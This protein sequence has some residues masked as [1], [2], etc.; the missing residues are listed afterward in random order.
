VESG[1]ERDCVGDV[2]SWLFDAA[3]DRANAFDS[4]NN[5]F[6]D[7]VMPPVTTSHG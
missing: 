2:S 3:A 5:R 6:L 4:P 1:S 7:F